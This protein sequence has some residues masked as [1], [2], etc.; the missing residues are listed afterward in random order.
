MMLLTP[1]QMLCLAPPRPGRKPGPVTV[2]VCVEGRQ[3][4][5]A[6]PAAGDSLGPTAFKLAIEQR[7]RTEFVYVE[8]TYVSTIQPSRGR[9]VSSFWVWS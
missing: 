2:S 1:S 4:R 6:T 5:T 8:P 3:C 7:Q 9:F